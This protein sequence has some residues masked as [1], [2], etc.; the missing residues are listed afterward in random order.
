VF[1]LMR[2]STLDM[3]KIQEE[4]VVEEGGAPQYNNKIIF[5]LGNKGNFGRGRGKGNFGRGGRGPIIC[6]N[7]NQ[8]RH[9]ACDCLNSCTRC[10]YYRALD[11]ATKYY[12]QIVA[13]WQVRGY[14]NQNPTQNV[15]KISIEK[16]NEGLRI[17]IVMRRGTRTG[18]DVTNGGKKMSKG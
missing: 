1:D 9:L 4:N 12:P 5:N 18:A 17:T 6:Y 10:T 8:P 7:C 11:H 3:Y 14:H 2:E 16:C 15:H 13:K